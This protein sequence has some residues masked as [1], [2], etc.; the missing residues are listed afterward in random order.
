MAT[1][2]AVMTKMYDVYRIPHECVQDAPLGA[3]FS[4]CHQT[5]LHQPYIL[6]APCVLSSSTM[7]GVSGATY[8]STNGATSKE[9]GAFMLN[10]FRFP[11]L[12][13][14]TTNTGIGFL[15]P[16]VFYLKIN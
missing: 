1:S 11:V 13:G 5:D 2:I 4:I 12:L 15:I 10:S 6:T 8:P 7:I 9:L 16:I 14:A 3:T